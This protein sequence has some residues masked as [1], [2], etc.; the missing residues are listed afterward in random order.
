MKKWKLPLALVLA[1]ALLACCAPAMSDQEAAVYSHVGET[2]ADFSVKTIDGETFSL[3][4]ALQEKELVLI[5]L[6]ATWCGPCESEFPFMQQ[7]YEQ[8]ADKVAIIALSVEPNDTPEVLTAYAESH[9]L[10]FSIG[11][12]GSTGLDDTFATVG[13]PTTIVVDRYGV[14]GYIGIG[15]MGSVGDFRSLFDHFTGED[16]TETDILE[17]LP[18]AMPTVDR[19][20][21]TELAAALGVQGVFNSP[22]ETV[23]PMIPAE[24]D[25]RSVL[26]SSNQG[27]G[28]TVCGVYWTAEAVE[29]DAL[30]FT[31]A[32]STETALDLLRV[33]VDDVIVKSFGGEH[34]WTDWAIALEPGVHT[35]GFEY[36]K[37][38]YTDSGVDTVWLD[39]VGVVSGDEA[40]A[41]L[42]ALPQYP[43][44]DEFAI[45]IENGDARRIQF[46]GDVGDLREAFAC[47][48]YWIV[49]GDAASA[50]IT[51]SADV[52]P[53][54]AFS[55]SNFDNEIQPLLEALSE[56]AYRVT[57]GVDSKLTTG[58]TYTNLYV[59]P[60]ADFLSVE[61]LRGV[62]LFASE[63]NVDAFI[64][65]MAA[66]GLTLTWADY[67]GAADTADA[68]GESAYTVLFTDQDGAP[69][70]GCVVN[71]CTDTA[72]VPV[73]ADENGA[74]VFT[75]APYAYHLQVIKVPEG[76]SFDTAQEFTADPNGGEISFTVTRN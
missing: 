55:Y 72:C 68:A 66:D 30:V 29:G 69:V 60:R 38:Y 35:V 62:M 49:P 57:T 46:S 47:D 33:I 27:E 53:E 14:I 71:F 41:A 36:Q 54:T 34:D 63:A 31:F 22:D 64:E 25:G 61:E 75:G 19:A 67:D 52:D 50:L 32:T 12:V 73:V 6:W 76:Y 44:A 7:A 2:L 3:A 18:P 56:G 65:E 23:W 24:R 48:S 51:L 21:E 74:A 16:Y 42:A 11:S 45:A 28:E 13:I 4:A 8:Y 20:D 5:N 9:G 70:P 26:V 40:A 43:V 17:E 15:A 1:L 59:Y 58:Y 10:T 39:S 37:D